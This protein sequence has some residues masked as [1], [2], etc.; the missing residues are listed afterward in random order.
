M[1]YAGKAWC[2]F[3]QY[4]CIG[5]CCA[6]SLRTSVVKANVVVVWC[7]HPGSGL[8]LVFAAYVMAEREELKP[9]RYNR[10]QKHLYHRW[11]DLKRCIHIARLCVLWGASF[12]VCCVIASRW[13]FFLCSYPAKYV[14]Y[15]LSVYA[16]RFLGIVY[17]RKL[18]ICH[19]LRHDFRPILEVQASLVHVATS[20]SRAVV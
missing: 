2:I 15:V 9:L 12:L 20:C 8:M 17:G 3:S 16:A 10:L 1:W 11:I 4:A 18:N 5:T 19:M 13:T 14:R 7:S 6:F